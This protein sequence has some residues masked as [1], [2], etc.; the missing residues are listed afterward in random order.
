MHAREV[1]HLCRSL[2]A[3]GV[4]AGTAGPVL[5]QSPSP[6]A[7]PDFRQ[8][9]EGLP[10]FLDEERVL[11]LH[12]AWRLRAEHSA[13]PSEDASAMST[14]RAAMER[15]KAMAQRAPEV[16]Q[17]AE[18]LSRLFGAT[19][20]EAEV[21]AEEAPAPATITTATT[22]PA[23]PATEAR[24]DAV[25]PAATG[26]VPAKPVATTVATSPTPAVE[27]AEDAPTQTAKARDDTPLD[28][29]Y[30]VGG[31]LPDADDLADAP[32][33]TETGTLPVTA[34]PAASMPPLPVRAP[35]TSAQ[36]SGAVVTTTRS[37]SR[38][39]HRSKPDPAY[40][41]PDQLRAFGWNTQPE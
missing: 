7:T 14:A 41:F 9:V 39:P 28:P 2:L 30:G 11:D 3:A 18:A 22:A 13:S 19:A 29:P 10:Q 20:T 17:R 4:L 12:R 38:T 35:E 37:A 32:E 27:P 24:G 6:F 40:V 36:K 34:K 21:A 8:F 33:A 31:P 16:R 25:K 1:R 15:R 26:S 5:A 23:R